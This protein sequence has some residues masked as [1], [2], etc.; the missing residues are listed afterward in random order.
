VIVA[1]SHV[2]TWYTCPQLQPRDE[3]VEQDVL[4]LLGS[5]DEGGNMAPGM[6]S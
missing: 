2:L 6:Q 5:L 3:V 4:K 1:K